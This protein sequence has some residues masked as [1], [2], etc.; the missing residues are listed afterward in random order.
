[1]KKMNRTNKFTALI[2]VTVII[3]AFIPCAFAEEMQSNQIVQFETPESKLPEDYD[4]AKIDIIN[5]NGAFIVPRK[6]DETA[7]SERSSA[8]SYSSSTSEFLIEPTSEFSASAI[9]DNTS[10]SLATG[11]LL[12]NKTLVSLPGRNGL[13]LNLAIRYNSSE[14]V[15]TKN[16]FE[17]N[18]QYDELKLL[19]D[20]FAIGWSFALPSISKK[21]YTRYGYNQETHLK[22]ADGREYK[23]NDI[24]TASTDREIT[25]VD[26][27]LNDL[28]LFKLAD[29][30]YRLVYDSGRIE[31]FDA[32]HGGIKKIKD[33]FGNEINFTYSKVNYYHGTLLEYHVSPSYHFSELQALTQITDSIGRTINIDYQ[34]NMFYPGLI[35]EIKISVEGDKKAHINLGRMRSYNGQVDVVENVYD[36]Y[37]EVRFDY[38]EVMSYLYLVQGGINFTD[39]HEL[40]GS[41]VLMSRETFQT[42]GYIDYKYIRLKEECTIDGYSG[43]YNVFKV[44]SASPYINQAE[45]YS[46]GV[47]EYAYTNTASNST[48]IKFPAT[49]KT[50]K[51]TF[52]DDYKL[53]KEEDNINSIGYI[54]DTWDTDLPTW[55]AYVNN[56][57]YCLHDRYFYKLGDMANEAVF[58]TPC[59]Y[60]FANIISLTTSG[61]TITINYTENNEAKEISFD[62]STY[63]WGQPRSA[64]LTLQNDATVSLVG[65]PKENITFEMEQKTFTINTSDDNYIL[66]DSNGNIQKS[67]PSD[68]CAVQQGTD[69]NL[70]M[71]TEDTVYKL[72]SNNEWEYYTLRVNT[73]EIADVI[74]GHNELIVFSADE[75]SLYEKISLTI[76]TPFYS[77]PAITTVEYSYNDFEQIT[78]KS[79]YKSSYNKS[80]KLEYSESW[81]YIEGKDALSSSTDRLGNITNYTYDNSTYYIPTTITSYAGEA[82]QEVV[83]TNMLS[84]DKTKIISSSTNYG[85]RI[86]TVSY[87]YNDSEIIDE[88]AVNYPGNVTKETYTEQLGTNNPITTRVI[89]YAY[90]TDENCPGNAYITKTTVKEVITNSVTFTQ[91]QPTNYI[92]SYTYDYDTGL[93]LSETNAKNQTTNYTY[94]HAGRISSITYPDSTVTRKYYNTF[95]QGKSVKTTYDNGYSEITYYNSLGE[96]S[97][98]GEKASANASETILKTYTPTTRPG[99]RYVTDAKENTLLYWYDSY[100]RINSVNQQKNNTETRLEDIYY[101]DYDNRITSMIGTSREIVKYDE[102]GREIMRSIKINNTESSR[103]GTEYDYMGNISKTTSP[104]GEITNYEYDRSGRLLKVTDALNQITTYEYDVYGNVSKV[105]MPAGNSISYEYDSLGR[106]L[107]QTDA[108]GNSEYYAYDE[109]GN[110]VSSKDRNNNVSTYTYKPNTNYLAN[111]QAGNIYQS[112]SVS[113]SYTYDNMGNRLSMTDLSGT[114]SYEY[115]YDKLLTKLTTPDNKSISYDYDVLKNVS[116]VTDYDGNEINYI[117]DELNR[118]SAISKDGSNLISYVY[119][120]RGNVSEYN[121]PGGSMLY[122]YD[123]ANR[124]TRIN[125]LLNSGIS[126][127]D[128]VYTYDLNGNILTKTNISEESTPKETTYTYDALSRLTTELLPDG[129]N[130]LFTYDANGNISSKS[131]THPSEYEYP[132]K[133]EGND[134]SVTAITGHTVNYTYDAN[135]RLLQQQELISGTG[136]N[137]TDALTVNTTF[138]YDANGNTLTKTKSGQVDESVVNY[139][140]NAVNNLTT[141][142]AADGTSTYYIYNGDN[143]RISK[144]TNFTTK[145]Y[146]DRGYVANEGNVDGITRS[147]YIG[148]NG[149]FASSLGSATN[150]GMMYYLKEA[151]CDVVAIIDSTGAIKTEYTY[152]AWGN[153]LTET[154]TATYETNIRYAGEYYDDESGLIYLRNRYYDPTIGRFINEDPIQDGLNW[155]VYCGNNPVMFTDPLGLWLP[156]DENLSYN[157]QTYTKYYGEQWEIANKK[158]INATTESE[159]LAAQNEKDYWHALAND[160]RALDAE[161]RIGGKVLDVPVYNQY[162]TAP[163]DNTNQLCWATSTAMMSSFYLEDTTDRTLYVATTIAQSNIVSVYNEPREWQSTSSIGLNIANNQTQ[164]SYPLTETQIQRTIDLDNP[165]GVLYGNYYIDYQ[166][167]ERWSGHWIVGIGYVTAPSHISLYISNDPAG[168]IQRVQTYDVFKGNYVGDPTPW[169]PWA[170]SAYQ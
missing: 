44:Q 123:D 94:D 40:N 128:Y 4:Q 145:Y 116:S 140:Y 109:I 41:H 98:I 135:N 112:E 27:P 124:I 147:N 24:T 148:I 28:T 14:A 46:L 115:R 39:Y 165:F 87:E 139:S 160:I 104:N 77:V 36:S 6:D 55:K 5:N 92:T 169:R 103:T 100:G 132:Y 15:I 10:V 75:P 72:N 99:G 90:N 23:I 49:S 45:Q 125:D 26:Y 32:T 50:T 137:I 18:S 110:V 54:G 131:I 162:D 21:G 95:Y 60:S 170:E 3:Q 89:E 7:V 168:G 97:K 158:Y 155:Y 31:E 2:L 144:M 166:G 154:E 152:D 58:F 106:L 133:S 67:L 64:Q 111:M 48:F 13:D 150:S 156:G 22:F 74:A 93:V 114:T 83:T 85:D 167:I 108:L 82:T 79:V 9:N 16:E 151:H 25:I 20:Q 57:L 122:S 157:A 130:T 129:T 88:I 11:A 161:G 30:S 134:Y 118:L 84:A 12:Y 127:V 146:W 59:P 142:T 63:T 138:T 19:S 73:G 80:K 163:S 33:K 143:L 78:E 56:D 70:Y 107:K 159:R 153:H 113:V 8:P 62:V 96:I 65:S 42:E 37:E 149:I 66:S 86:S 119:D 101:D 17:T 68:V 164:V 105:T 52:N 34:K 47:R 69:D 61:N 51:Y 38:E 121:Y 81:S 117:Y 102:L 136:E 1:M 43:W 29:N 35:E 76:D 53:I 71:F 120:N 91:S 126:S 141:F